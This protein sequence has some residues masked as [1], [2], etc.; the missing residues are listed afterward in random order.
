MGVDYQTYSDAWCIWRWAPGL[1]AVW[2]VITWAIIWLRVPPDVSCVVR[3]S[4]AEAGICNAEDLELS[5]LQVRQRDAQ[6]EVEAAG[7]WLAEEERR[8]EWL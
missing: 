6:Q 4:T 2:Q 3:C 7:R 8:R 1:V 5:G